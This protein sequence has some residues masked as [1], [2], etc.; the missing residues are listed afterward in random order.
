[1]AT[2]N[3]PQ[4]N[5]LISHLPLADYSALLSHLEHVQLALGDILKEPGAPLRY[6]YFPTTAII[7]YQNLLENGAST[8]VAMVG[9]EGVL[10]I[11]LFMSRGITPT[12]CVVRSPGG[13]YRLPGQLLQERFAKGG[14]FQQ[15]LLN[16]TQTFI[17]QITQIA[18]CNR[19][20]SVDQQLCRWLLSNLD[21]L[22]S[23]E[24]KV[25]HEL[26]ATMLGVRREGITEAAGNL[27]IAELIVCKRG[28]ITVLDRVGMEARVCEC[29]ATIKLEYCP[30]PAA[31]H[32][33]A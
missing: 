22:Q 20:H 8:E 16:Y 18:I 24:L 2:N 25:T 28:C 1:M 30:S 15:I 13:A 7:S 32:L 29:Y 6:A 3:H 9:N 17:T 31:I 4:Q 27:Q 14:A 12:R 21:R 11:S 26:I 33:V 10:G 23:D 5:Q 19:H